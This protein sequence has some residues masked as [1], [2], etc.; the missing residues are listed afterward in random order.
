[1]RKELYLLLVLAVVGCGKNQESTSP[2]L[3]FG[4]PENLRA[5]SV[6]NTTVALLWV[7]P[8]GQPDS[9]GGYVVQV[10]N[11]RDTLDRTATS[12]L[13]DSLTPG[14]KT[15]A[16]YAR[17]KSGTLS[18]GAVIKWAPA[19]RFD[20]PVVLYEYKTN[21]TSVASA[22]D[23]G[24]ASLSPSAM[25]VTAANAG[26]MD[27]YLYGGSGSVQD[28]L[29]LQSASLLAQGT[30]YNSTKFSTTFTVSSGLNYFL[31]AFPD[32]ATFTLDQAKVIDNTVYYVRVVGDNGN[33]N[34]ARIH[35]H[36]VPGA[37]FPSR[38][39]EIRVSLQRSPGL[40]Y[41]L[42]DDRAHRPRALLGLIALPGGKP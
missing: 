4:P 7:A 40:L 12:F 30:A 2:S 37:V 32:A 6:N 41:A 20:S 27:I 34:Y 3:Q 25:T 29:Q 5:Q 33:T 31:A 18:T 11:A 42:R 28:T 35:V 10:G 13:A 22:L 15:F 8:S 38:A 14:E 17:K 36:V 23:V 26:L 1:M 19:A 24:S 39:V 9:L 16:V 21:Q